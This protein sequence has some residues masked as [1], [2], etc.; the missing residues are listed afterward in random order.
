MGSNYQ[1]L[2]SL[3]ELVVDCPHSTPK[4]MDEGF[5]VLRN[6]NIRNGTLDLTSPSFT[7]EN[8]YKSRVKRAIPR[9]GDIVFT[10][11]APM[12]EVCVIPEGL[13]CCL[14]QRQ[15]LLRPKSD[16]DSQYLF[17][18][19]QSPHVQHQISWNE[20]TGTTVSNVRIPVLKALEIPRHL[21]KERDIACQL[22]SLASRIELNK[23]TNQTLEQMAQALFK[24]W[25]VD[26]DPVIDNA[27]A[28]GNTIPDELQAR[29]EV[30]KKAIAERVINPKLKPLP[31][32][33]QQLFPSELEYCGDDSLGIQGWIPQGWSVSD[34]GT[35]FV[36]LGGSTPSTKNPEFW[37][38]GDICWTSPKDLSGNSTKILLE[39]NRKITKVGLKKINSGLLPV[40][41]VLMSSRAPVG[42]LALAKVPLAINQGYIA[43]K[44]KKTLSPE[45]TI[46]FLDSIMDEIKGIS[47]GTTF[48]EI[49]KKTF[50]SIK[51]VIPEKSVVNVYT[52]IIEKN[53]EKITQN[54]KQT[55]SLIKMRDSLLPK[56][57]SGE[58]SLIGE[59]VQDQIDA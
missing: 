43:L 50:R 39:T 6:Q 47:G 10:R 4:W 40:D 31:E 3:C 42:Y 17:W 15:V 37:E 30:R 44:C 33:I 20:G 51:L 34:T 27:L 25:F 9:A 8:G 45:F 2:E 53:Y 12:G 29:A 28:A 21:G 7:N 18:A 46:Q 58:V 54:V 36:V 52:D 23:Q 19:L 48:A 26:F 5:I 13:T 35:E 59:R 11:E 16:V 1:S 38:D 22:S 14:G 41:T 32:D 57:I 49:S 56:L 55:K 24:S